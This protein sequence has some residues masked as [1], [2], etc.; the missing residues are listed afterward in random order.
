M[1]TFRLAIDIRRAPSDSLP[2][3]PRWRKCLS[4]MT[5]SNT[6]PRRRQDQPRLARGTR[7]CDPFR[8]SP[9]HNDVEVTQYELNSKVTLESREG[10]TPFRYRYR[11][12]R[13]T[14]APCH[15]TAPSA[16]WAARTSRPPRP[17]SNPVLQDGMNQ[18]LDQLKRIVEASQRDENDQRAATW[19]R[20]PRTSTPNAHAPDP[21]PLPR[22]ATENARRRGA[23]QFDAERP[24]C[25]CHV[26]GW[27]RVGEHHIDKV[28][29]EGRHD[30]S[31]QP[32]QHRRCPAYPDR[33]GV[34][35]AR[36]LFR[37]S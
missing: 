24:G 22:T 29:C 6:S 4:G 14:K 28:R 5:R 34:D 20:P 17:A 23:V 19:T 30:T 31:E 25:R 36:E 32:G 12:N 13:T 11:S 26:L 18:N 33:L 35:Q 16:G 7:S 9:V 15:S 8:A 10:P 21:A 27:N 3:S 37:Q 1:G 2:S